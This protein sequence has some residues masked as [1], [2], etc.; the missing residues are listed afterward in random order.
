MTHHHHHD[1][2]PHPSAAAGPSLLR[3]SAPRRLAVAGFVI[4]LLWAAFFWVSH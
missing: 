3:L 2:G 4:G 1:D